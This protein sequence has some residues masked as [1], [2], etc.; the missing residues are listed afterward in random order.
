MT[1]IRGFLLLSTI[2]RYMHITLTYHKEAQMDL[3]QKLLW[4]N[5]NLWTFSIASFLSDVSI[6]STLAIL[7]AYFLSLSTPELAPL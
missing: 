1:N 3:K 6:E 2:R 4:K 7:P 5:A